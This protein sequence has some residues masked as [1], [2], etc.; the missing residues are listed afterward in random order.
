[1]FS[2]L[3][4]STGLCSCCSNQ[5]CI[6]KTFFIKHESCFVKKKGKL[7]VVHVKGRKLERNGWRGDKEGYSQS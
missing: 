1:M 4:N 3:N 7:D 6:L 2:G 5:I